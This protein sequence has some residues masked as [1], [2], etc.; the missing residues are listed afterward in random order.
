MIWELAS[1]ENEMKYYEIR[2]DMKYHILNLCRRLLRSL[3][4]GYD[5]NFEFIS[6]RIEVFMFHST[7][8]FIF[9]QLHYM[10]QEDGLLRTF[11]K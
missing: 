6:I 10:K 2:N 7:Y 8:L 11:A 1:C 5:R 9:I 3:T 4:K